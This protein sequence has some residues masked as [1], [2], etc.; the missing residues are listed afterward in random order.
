[1]RNKEITKLRAAKIKL[2]ITDI[3]GVW[4]DGGLYYTAEGLIMKRFNVKDGM[5]VNRLRDNGIET[6]IISG[7]NSPIIKTRGEKLKLELIYLG[8]ADKKKALDEICTIR[9]YRYEN[10]AFIGDDVNDLCLIEHVGISA[11]PVD[12]V[13]EILDSVDYICSR[14]GGDGAFREF[15]EIMLKALHL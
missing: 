11:A 12:A 8:I 2:V 1:M 14:K 10:I 3:D 7:D 5:G 6:G 13:D 4:T 9:N 15:A